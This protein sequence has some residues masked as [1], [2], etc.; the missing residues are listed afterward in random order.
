MTP[1]ALF[2]L[3]N[4]LASLGWLCLALLPLHRTW[5]M[6]IGG[7]LIPIAL[8]VIYAA[9]ILVYWSGAEGGFDSLANVMLLFDTP[10]TALA[11][12]VHFLAFDLFVGAWIARDAP[13]CGIPHWAILPA[14]VLTFLFGPIGL[15]TYLA[16][17]A[18]LALKSEAPS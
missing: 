9:L 11:G 4:P 13:R 8:S 1:D 5:L 12:W 15:L 3:T 2:G 16:L 10:G 18:V 17:R 6:R 14:L 7:W